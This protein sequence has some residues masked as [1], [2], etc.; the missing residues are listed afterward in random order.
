ML[1]FFK[2]IAGIGGIAGIVALLWRVRDEFKSWLRIEVEV[3]ATTAGW[4]SALTIVE[5]KGNL[6]K[7]LEY[8]C[9]LIGP[10]EEEPVLTA[11][12]IARSLDSNAQIT[13]TDHIAKVRP[14]GPVYHNG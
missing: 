6:A 4:A 5:N 11:Q 2:L 1:E 9:L 12:A 3:V 10:I 8:A 7:P 13:D 14:L